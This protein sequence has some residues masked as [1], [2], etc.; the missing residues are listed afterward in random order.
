MKCGA[1]MTAPTLPAP[2]EQHS[3]DSTQAPEQPPV[4]T[5]VATNTEAGSVSVP[6]AA[7]GAINMA[8]HNLGQTGC[9]RCGAELFPGPVQSVLGSP[10][11]AG[12]PVAAAPLSRSYRSGGIIGVVLGCCV[13]I[14]LIVY[15]SGAMH[16]SGSASSSPR[17][18]VIEAAPSATMEVTYEVVGRDVYAVSL[19]WEKD[20]GGGAQGD[21]KL[22]FRTTYTMKTGD[23]AYIS[24]QIIQPTEGA[25][26][27][28][29][30]IY[31]NG[32]LTY[33]GEASGF[34]SI[35][36]ASGSVE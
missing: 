14:A 33:Q 9:G 31:I 2:A 18:P 15:F 8:A 25:G 32:V 22:P 13:I 20:A 19:T 3:A 30:R 6:C 23:F 1:M 7:C 4:V 11:K 24:A 26:S 36:T 17:L 12:S 10:A 16:T 29:S 27:I 35:A 21:Y 34:P 28:E 5:A